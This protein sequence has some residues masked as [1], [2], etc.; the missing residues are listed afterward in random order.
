MSK[1]KVTVKDH[2]LDAFMRTIKAFSG[3]GGLRAKVGIQGPQAEKVGKREGGPTNVELGTIHEFGAPSVGIPARP[4]LRPV[5]DER[6]PHWRTRLR[7]E[8]EAAI[9]GRVDPRRA[10]VTVGEEFR[11]AVIDRIKAHIDPPLAEST[12]ARKGE[13]VPLIDTGSLVGS[14][15]S[16]VGPKE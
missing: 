7:E 2:G 16:V 4:F 14:I 13:D 10:L 6:M 11:T 5:A 15:S 8:A 12:I 9:A 3:L 1:S